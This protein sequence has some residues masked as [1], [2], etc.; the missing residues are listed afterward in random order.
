MTLLIIHIELI[1][2]NKGIIMRLEKFKMLGV[3]AI[4]IAAGMELHPAN[5]AQYGQVVA[6]E[7]KVEKSEPLT[8]FSMMGKVLNK[9]AEPS[10][11][12]EKVKALNEQTKEVMNSKATTSFE[13]AR[14]GTVYNVNVD[15]RVTNEDILIASTKKPKEVKQPKSQKQINK[16]DILLKPTDNPQPQEVASKPAEEVK[17]GDILLKAWQGTKNVATNVAEKGKESF[18]AAK[19]KADAEYER[20]NGEPKVVQA[21]GPV[22][23]TADDVVKAKDKVV[24]GV[25]NFLGKLRSSPKT[26]DTNKNKPNQ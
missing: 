10:V 14:Y 21:Q 16:G 7:Q 18:M 5:A 13:T 17:P 22:H 1:I 11:E 26:E 3:A 8:I 15:D 6:Q 9:K 4:V 19:A 23:V 12:A 24:D 25:T 20:K 2:I